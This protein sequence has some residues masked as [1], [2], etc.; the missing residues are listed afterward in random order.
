MYIVAAL[1]EM[2]INDISRQVLMD[3]T[4]EEQKLDDQ[5]FSLKH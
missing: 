2:T 4:P 3:P 5:L 1:D